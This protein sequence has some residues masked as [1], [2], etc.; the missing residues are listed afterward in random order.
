MRRVYLTAEGACKCIDPN[1]QDFINLPVD[2]DEKY[3]GHDGVLA[4][5]CYGQLFA[6]CI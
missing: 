1:P 5:Y 4:F 6:V 3:C 2:L